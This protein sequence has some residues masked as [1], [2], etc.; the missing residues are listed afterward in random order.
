MDVE[1]SA[2]A[3]LKPKSEAIALFLDML[4]GDHFVHQL[5]RAIAFLLLVIL[6]FQGDHDYEI[7][8]GRSRKWD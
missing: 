4:E 5:S 7:R 6:F 3:P 8:K 2:I 1:V